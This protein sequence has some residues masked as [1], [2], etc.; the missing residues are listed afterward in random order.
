MAPPASL[1][2]GHRTAGRA[3]YWRR[4]V[5]VMLALLLACLIATV[6]ILLVQSYR[7]IERATEIFD[8]GAT[9][10]TVLANVLREANLLAIAIERLPRSGDLEA[11]RLRRAFLARQLSVLEGLG[12]SYPSL[13]RSLG[14][15]EAT[16]A[17]LDARLRNPRRLGPEALRASLSPPVARLERQVK[18]AFDEEEHAL[19][20]ALAEAVRR[21]EHSQLL[22]I[23]LGTLALLTAMRWPRSSAAPSG[24]TSPA[25]TARSAPRS[26]SARRWSSGWSTRRGTI[27]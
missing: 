18:A 17:V 3:P 21:R 8:R 9:V 5:S 1:S 13:R 22:L 24:R 19:Y 12:R 26:T 16:V 27:R 25:R 15:T 10:S 11:I 2:A 20:E 14:E 4:P 23:G 7:E 6:E